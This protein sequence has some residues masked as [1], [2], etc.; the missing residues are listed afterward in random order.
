[1]DV[2]QNMHQSGTITIGE[3]LYGHSLTELEDRITALKAEI[4][5]VETELT[6]KRAERNAADNV[7]KSKN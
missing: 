1:M 6:E 5:R 3:D 4:T 2:N 7:F